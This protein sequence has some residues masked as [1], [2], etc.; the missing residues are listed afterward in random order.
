MSEVILVVLR[1]PEMAA[2]LL[3]AASRLAA[4]TGEVRINV[5][6]P[7]EPIHVHPLAAEELMN[8]TDSVL[9]C[10]RKGGQ[11]L[12]ALKHSF[13]RWAA[14]ASQAAFGAHWMEVQGS[15]AFFWSG[16]SAAARTSSWPHGPRMMTGRRGRRSAP[17][18]SALT[19]RFSWCRL[20]RSRSSAALSRSPGET[21]SMR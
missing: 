11:R 3:D 21:K 14:E 9:A 10:E 16:E 1:R 17:R 19:G 5:L 8:E 13:E 20:A 4:L 12:G 2:V 18:Y 6:A 7:R 15:A